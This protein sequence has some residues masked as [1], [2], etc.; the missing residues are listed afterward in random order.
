MYSTLQVYKNKTTQSQFPVWQLNKQIIC[1]QFVY[2][3]LAH[4]REL[5]EN[6]LTWALKPSYEIIPINFRCYRKSYSPAPNPGGDSAK[7][8]SEEGHKKN[9]KKSPKN[10]S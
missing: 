2:I 10:F 9:Y 4:I 8:S 5:T 7:F 6:H 1:S 3:L